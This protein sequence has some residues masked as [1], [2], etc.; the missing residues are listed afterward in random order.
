M[1]APLKRASQTSRAIRP[2]GKRKRK[3]RLS[4]FTIVELL[5]STVVL[6]FLVLLLA[7]ISN[8]ANNAWMTSQG[9]NERRQSGRAIVD[10]LARDLQFAMLPL[11]S[12]AT[13]SLQFIKNPP[14]VTEKYPD[15][16][17][18]QAPVAT[19][20][21]LGDIAEVGYFVRWIEN[22]GRPQAVLCRLLVNPAESGG[23]PNPNYRIVSR[24]DEWINS[25]LLD[26]AAPANKANDYTGLF[27]ENIIGLWTRCLDA[28]GNDLRDF[29]S[30]QSI[31]PGQ[32]PA[33]VQVGVVVIDSRAASR[34]TP[35]L[36]DQLIALAQDPARSPDAAAFVAVLHADPAFAALSQGARAFSTIVPLIN[37]K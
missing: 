32:L 34:M 12:Q 31:P 21:A 16:L 26:T 11:P 17:F 13:N 35:A 29:D 1:S 18:W 15:A 10:A 19:Q 8:Q 24:P 30:R 6:T 25:A 28:S 3:G 9:T 33:M 23:L 20:S 4:A 37:S 14:G 5:V 27:A 22:A 2:A 7:G 36:R